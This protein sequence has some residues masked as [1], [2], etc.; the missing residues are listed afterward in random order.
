M[1]IK[2]ERASESF[3]LKIPGF[4]DFTEISDSRHYY[5]VP[6]DWLVIVSDIQGSTQ[7]VQCGRYND[8]N[9][10]GAACITTVLNAT[11]QDIPFVFGGDGASLLIPPDQSEVVFRVLKDLI[12]I[13]K[14]N[15]G[16]ILKAGFVPIHELTKNGFQMEI[17]RFMP[18]GNRSIALFRGGAL[19]EAEK[20]IKRHSEYQLTA[21][22]TPPDDLL[23]NGLTCRW[24]KISSKKGITLS[25]LITPLPLS[26]NSQM[27][28]VV[29]KIGE[30]LG[31][32]L[33]LGN[34]VNIEMSSY[35]S[36]AQCL[37]QELRFH[38][39]WHSPGYMK[40]VVEIGM[41]VPLFGWGLHSYFPKANHYYGNLKS[42][43]DFQ[44]YDDTLRMIIDCSEE[45]SQ[46]IEGYLLEAEEKGQL[47][48]GFH[49]SDGA[50]MTCYVENLSDGNHLHFIDGGNGGYSL[51]SIRLKD[52]LKQLQP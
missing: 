13:S 29:Q 23:F 28:V 17:A 22:D 4:S 20:R 5:S 36:I 49:R 14:E 26:D 44:K 41:A 38:P 40:R 7:A 3:Y 33:E 37:Q 12:R 18:W 6:D 32:N 43:S 8:V 19:A 2:S 42:H 10:I 1:V 24:N 21:D 11:R 31:G 52:R 39:G 34:P 47:V 46:T 15:F 35:K 50:Q 27:G 51:A 9:L 48:Y 30:I 45:Q 25:L 16:L